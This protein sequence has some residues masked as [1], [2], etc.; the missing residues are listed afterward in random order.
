MD[1]VMG[2]PR[3]QCN[4]DAVGV[5]VDHLTKTAHFFLINIKYSLE[6]LAQ[7]YIREVVRLHGIPVTIVSDRD[8]WFTRTSENNFNK[9]LGRN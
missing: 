8:P 5:I 1:F 4:H 3:S 2:L 6:N 7:L 9:P